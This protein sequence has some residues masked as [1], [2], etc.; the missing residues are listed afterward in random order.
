MIERLGAGAVRA[1]SDG[2][3]GIAL[4]ARLHAYVNRGRWLADCPC[5]G[6]DTVTRDDP[7]FWCWDCHNT[8]CGGLLARVVF[9]PDA[10]DAARLLGR[11]KDARVQ[12]WSPGEN[13][14]G[15]SIATWLRAENIVHGAEPASPSERV[16]AKA[17]YYGTGAVQA[18]LDRLAELGDDDFDELV[19]VGPEEFARRRK[20]GV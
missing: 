19:T 20:R 10:E 3:T 17:L 9:P 14:D 7:V 2:I 6:A 1:R 16:R 5:N 15:V 4:D 8:W 11:R 18:E 12:N 13:P